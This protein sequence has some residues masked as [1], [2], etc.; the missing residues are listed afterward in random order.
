[1]LT[2]DDRVYFVVFHCEYQLGRLM[3]IPGDTIPFGQ[4]F[5]CTT[6][7]AN[8]DSSCLWILFSGLF[9]VDF[10]EQ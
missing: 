5:H 3:P 1:M 2:Y 4:F 8:E 7:I 9:G 10:N 6:V